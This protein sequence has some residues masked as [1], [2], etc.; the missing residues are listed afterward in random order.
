MGGVCDVTATEVVAK[1]E[2]LGGWVRLEGEC[3]RCRIPAGAGDLRAEL[4]R[5]RGAIL[6]FLR[7]HAA[8]LNVRA[9]SWA[10]GPRCPGCKGTWHSH[11]RLSEHMGVCRYVKEMKNEEA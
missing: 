5:H 2:A 7:P 6:E 3:L 8:A 11:E 4:Q 1:L 10:V 9:S